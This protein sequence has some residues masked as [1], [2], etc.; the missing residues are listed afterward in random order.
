MVNFF[1]HLQNHQIQV[2]VSLFD[3]W[4]PS[5]PSAV[6]S[7]DVFTAPLPASRLLISR[8]FEEKKKFHLL[9]A[10]DDCLLPL[11]WARGSIQNIL[12]EVNGIFQLFKLQFTPENSILSKLLVNTIFYAQV[13]FP[14][15]HAGDTGA[16][17]ETVSETKSLKEASGTNILIA[18]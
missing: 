18:M 1:Y 15:T 5:E 4:L 3:A 11:S 10:G 7:D 14:N 16:Q 12:L 6:P 9:S 8:P 17:R 13:F 2:R